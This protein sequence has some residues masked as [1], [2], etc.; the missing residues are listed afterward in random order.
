VIGAKMGRKLFVT[1]RLEVLLHFVERFTYGLIGR[2]EPPAAFGAAKSP[3]TLV[4]NPYQHSLHGRLSRLAPTCSSLL[5]MDETRTFGICGSFHSDALPDSSRTP[6]VSMGCW[7]IDKYMGK[8]NRGHFEW[9]VGHPTYKE[10]LG[11]RRLQ[12]L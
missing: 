11:S 9:S 12:F 6:S 3:K 10:R 5:S 2:F 7:K 8:V 1:L 4:L